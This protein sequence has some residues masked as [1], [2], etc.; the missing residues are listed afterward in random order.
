MKTFIQ[1]FSVFGYN[2]IEDKWFSAF[3]VRQIEDSIKL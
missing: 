3:E 1:C 2:H